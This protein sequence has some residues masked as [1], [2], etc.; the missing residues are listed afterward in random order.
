MFLKVHRFP[1]GEIVALC[2]A[3]LL[4]RV[5]TDGRRVLDLKAHA[6]FYNGRKVG[7][8]EAADA[9]RGAASINVV[10]K[11]SVAAAAAAGIRT[12]ASQAIGGVPHLQ[13]YSVA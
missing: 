8:K 11:K 3:E 12:A 1:G 4:G 10:G 6:S 9:L 7:K 2:D 13:A 5:L